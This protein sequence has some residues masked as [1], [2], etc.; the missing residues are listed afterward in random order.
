[1]SLISYVY[2]GKYAHIQFNRDSGN[3]IIIGIIKKCINAVMLIFSKH[4]QNPKY[5][6]RK[7]IGHKNVTNTKHTNTLTL[8]SNFIYDE[9]YNSDAIQIHNTCYYIQCKKNQ[10]FN[11]TFVSSIFV[12]YN[13]DLDLYF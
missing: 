12:I 5:L 8:R 2:Y 3:N 6:R 10:P 9:I 11:I 7:S 4:F 13:L 1:M